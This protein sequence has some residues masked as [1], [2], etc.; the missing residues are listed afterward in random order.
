M[1]K[2]KSHISQNVKTAGY[3]AAAIF[4]LGIAVLAGLYVEQN[5][6]VMDVRFTGN[7]FTEEED[8]LNAMESPVGLMADSININSLV[9]GLEVLPYVEQVS[10]SMARR[11]T[12]SMS[13]Q[14]REPIGLLIN[15]GK[16]M[17][18]DKNGIKLPDILGKSVDLP[19]VY[20]FNLE[21]EQDTLTGKHF[22]QVRDFLV[23]TKKNP[24]AWATISEV[25]WNEREGVVALSSENGV[26]LVFGHE[27][28]GRKL[29]HWQ[30][31]NAEV[32]SKKGIEAF[33]TVDLRF[34]DQI[35]AIEQ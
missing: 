6:R 4:L 2:T 33:R 26:K 17:Y 9:S 25:A 14:E 1:T 21:N 13:I 3:F 30:A 7:H 27:N 29:T 10:V 18:M 19:L 8:L 24:F 31:F 23:E 5:T 15:N 35:V 22:E 28:F 12:L 20:G 16:K 34:R 11:G 32:V